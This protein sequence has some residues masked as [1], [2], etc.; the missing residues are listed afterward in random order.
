MKTTASKKSDWTQS[1]HRRTTGIGSLPHHNIDTALEYAF[2]FGVPF[3]PQIPIRNPREFMIAQA[4]ERLPGIVLQ[5][6]Q[7]AGQVFLDLD[8]W[9]AQ[10]HLLEIKLKRAFTEAS[11]PDAFQNF[12]P[13]ASVASCWEPFLWE[14]EER[15]LK[16]A[17]IQIM[18]PLTA[19]WAL[20]VKNSNANENY[21]ELTTQI[22]RLILAQALAMTRRMR[23]AG[24]A[25]LLYLDEPG[26]YLLDLKHPRH[27]LALQELKLVIQTLQ[28]EGARVGLH[29]CS[30][31]IWESVLDLGL[32]ILSI[33][34]A[35]SLGAAVSAQHGQAMKDYLTRGGILSLGIVP[36]T[37]SSVLSSLNS[38]T[39]AEQSLAVLVEHLDSASVQRILKTS[40]FTPACGLGLQSNS[41][42]E[43]I[44]EKLNEV[45]AYFTS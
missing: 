12:E 19:Q 7:E 33:D 15:N 38:Q 30:N 45:Y 9:K 2:Q 28:Q 18:G 34:T 10:A 4:L 35:L 1:I 39:I 27:I 31:T 32:D 25:P 8:L 16:V 13:R 26:F 40:L 36:T 3:L 37:H 42:C 23:A 11:N 41:D 44:L 29:C 21:P 20:T 24:I 14:L 6:G 43:L 17:K 22:F 5:N